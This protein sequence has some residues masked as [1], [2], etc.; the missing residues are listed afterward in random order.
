MWTMV[1]SVIVCAVVLQVKGDNCPY[2]GELKAKSTSSVTIFNQSLL[3]PYLDYFRRQQDGME[4]VWT[5]KASDSNK[6]V[7]LVFPSFHLIKASAS[8]KGDCVAIYDADQDDIGSKNLKE[9]VCFGI[10]DSTY[11]STGRYLTVVFRQGVHAGRRWFTM[12][13]AMVSSDVSEGGAIL[14]G[15]VNVC[16]S[17]I[18]DC[19]LPQALGSLCECCGECL[20]HLYDC[21]H[22]CKEES[23]SSSN[24]ASEPRRVSGAFQVP[25][26]VRDDAGPN[27]ISLAGLEEPVG[28]ENTSSYSSLDIVSGTEAA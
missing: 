21:L 12:K 20:R 19:D 26:L 23:C 13:Y 4:C 22:D 18:K 24:S 16:K 15:I 1:G 27:A 17:C 25:A 6:N 7:G 11:N 10:P 8:G 9:E 2:D 28:G 3:A 5:I 14:C